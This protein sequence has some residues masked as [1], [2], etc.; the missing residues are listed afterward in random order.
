MRSPTPWPPTARES[1]A[2]DTRAVETRLRI[3]F[4]AWIRAL[5]A[6]VRAKT[7]QPELESDLA[8]TPARTRAGSPSGV[9]DRQ[10][11]NSILAAGTG[12]H[13]GALPGYGIRW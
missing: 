7:R 1:L 5:L 13:L 3:W 2:Q 10:L 8:W 9:V 11:P 4:S 6:E 12:C